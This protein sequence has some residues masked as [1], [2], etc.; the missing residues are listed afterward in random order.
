[1]ASESRIRELCAQALEEKDREKFKAIADELKEALH[2]HI[3]ELRAL[4]K[5]RAATHSR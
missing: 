4:V 5:K 2:E 3:N 1:M